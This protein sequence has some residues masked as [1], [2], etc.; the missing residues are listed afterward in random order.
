[1]STLAIAILRNVEMGEELVQYVNRIDETL[2]PFGGRF[3]VHGGTGEPLEG[4]WNSELVIIQFPD[5]EHARGWYSS[6]A[7][8]AILKLRTSN[9]DGDAFLIDTVADGH[10]AT[11][12][13][14]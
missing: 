12:I 7:Y 1:M 10:R 9:S 6:D 2:L 3:L 8:Q 5:R 11:D 4:N 13:L 14:L